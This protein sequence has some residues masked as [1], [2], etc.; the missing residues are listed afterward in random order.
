MN[1]RV[2]SYHLTVLFLFISIAKREKEKINLKTIAF[3]INLL[4]NEEKVPKLI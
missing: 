2:R 3:R 1:C 4:I